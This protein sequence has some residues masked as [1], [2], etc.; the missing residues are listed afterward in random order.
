ML[1]DVV[2]GCQVRLS[3]STCMCSVYMSETAVCGS[4]L[5]ERGKVVIRSD[6]AAM[7]L[8]S[9]AV[10]AAW[11][12]KLGLSDFTAR[13]K[14]LGWATAGEFAFSSSY[15]PGQPNPERFDAEVTMKILEDPQHPKCAAVRRL[16]FECHHGGLGDEKEELKD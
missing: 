3:V 1:Q 4:S 11:L 7:A 15:T 9:E 12:A 2:I 10:F 16:Y 13:F 6:T 14:E 8:E 5:L